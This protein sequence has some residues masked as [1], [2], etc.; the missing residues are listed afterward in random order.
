MKAMKYIIFLGLMM[1]AQGMGAQGVRTCPMRI[2]KGDPRNNGQEQ[3][4]IQAD[5][6]RRL[7]EVQ[8]AA[9]HTPGIGTLTLPPRVLVIMVNFSNYTFST[10]REEADST[11]NAKKSISTFLGPKGGNI[12]LP[13]GSVATYFDDQSLG[14]YRPQF[15]V[16]GP[17]TLSGTYAYY[18][19]GTGTSA[20]PKEMVK[21]ACGLVDKEVDF[22]Q[23][24]ADKDGYIDLVFVYFAG[25]GENDGN[26][27]DTKFVPTI[28]DLV[29]PHYST[30][31]GSNKFDG[32]ILRAYECCNEL[33]GYYSQYNPKCL[34]PSGSGILVHEFSHGMGLPDVYLGADQFMGTWDLMDYGCYSGGTFIPTPYNGYQRWFC[35]WAQPKMMNCIKNDTLRPITESGDFGV[36]TANGT[37]NGPHNGGTEYWIIENHQY[38]GWDVV[39][40]DSGLLLYHMKYHSAWSSS[41]NYDNRKGCILLPADGTL[42]YQYEGDWF[43]GKPGD[44]YPYETLDSITTIVDKYPITKIKQESN[45]NIT[46]KVCGGWPIPTGLGEMGE[47]ARGLKGEK[48]WRNG[49]LYIRRGNKLYTITGNETHIL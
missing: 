12:S 25:F 16:V 8:D 29:W 2:V 43:V 13:H 41:T 9:M 34:V 24:D 49:T 17:V 44:C 27:I 7:A 35:G 6:Q 21:E 31:S 11:F 3:Q 40:Q 23:Y 14:Q 46:F 22:T 19:A 5:H 36:I 20:R 32:K 45:G 33:D 30:I 18:G 38:T 26:Y 37:V 48:V 42:R 15:D 1:V 10:T 4:M 47:E 28:T 39:A